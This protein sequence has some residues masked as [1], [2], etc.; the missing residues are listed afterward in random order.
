MNDY[1]VM[2]ILCVFAWDFVFC[3][4]Q[5]LYRTEKIEGE[6]KDQ[7]PPPISP[8]SQCKEQMARIVYMGESKGHCP[9][10]ELEWEGPWPLD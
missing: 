8:G 10:S 4:H 3:Q 2:C 6:Y 1:S 9:S 7:P 5:A